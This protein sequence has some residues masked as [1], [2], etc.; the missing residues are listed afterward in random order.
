[1]PYVRGPRVRA[2]H[3]RGLLKRPTSSHTV[4]IPSCSTVKQLARS[5]VRVSSLPCCVATERRPFN[6]TGKPLTFGAFASV[7]VNYRLTRSLVGSHFLRCF[8]F[9]HIIAISVLTRPV[10]ANITVVSPGL[11][12]SRIGHTINSQD[13]GKSSK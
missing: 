11:Y 12:P 13:S 7:A 5:R 9:A 1:M 3:P 6:S 10:N 2:L 4:M 8:P